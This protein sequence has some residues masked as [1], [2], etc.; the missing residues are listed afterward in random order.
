MAALHYEVREEIKRQLELTEKRAT[1]TAIRGS[2]S[3]VGVIA[4][5]AGGLTYLVVSLESAKVAE[6]VAKETATIAVSQKLLAT[7]QQA[8]ATDDYVKGVSKVLADSHADRLRGPKGPPGPPRPPSMAPGAV[9]AI[10]SSACPT[11]WDPY[12][13]AAGR[14]IIGGGAHGA[15]AQAR[16]LGQNGKELAL[17]DVGKTGGTLEFNELPKH[18][19]PGSTGPAE[20]LI[21]YSQVNGPRGNAI[22]DTTRGG[23]VTFREDPAVPLRI[24]E[25]GLE[26]P[27]NNLPPYVVLQ[28]CM[29]GASN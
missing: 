12:Y 15:D 5:V 17:L 14:F 24:A 10:A 13:L 25:A 9:I 29:K 28:F 16:N 18:E 27:Q 20:G 6:E 19:H 3:L 8:V 11:G 22:G 7:F 4:A 23:S 26:H 2:L 1:L 21:V